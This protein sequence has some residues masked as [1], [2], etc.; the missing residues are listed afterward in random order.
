MAW[1]V[2]PATVDRFDDFATVVNRTRRVNHCWCLSPRLTLRDIEA[3]GEGS[4]ELAMRRLCERPIPPGVIAY[5]EGEP[6]GWCNAGPRSDMSRLTHSRVIPT[7]D[8]VPVWSVVCLVV[9]TGYR[10]QG[11]T[12]QLLDGVVEHARRHGAPVLEAYPVEPVGRMDVTMAFVGTVPMFERAGFHKV[13]QTQGHS[14]GLVR[15]L[16]RRDLT[17]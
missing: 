2:L 13:T 8:D 12:G 5:R 7:L 11:V 9:R 4:R 14:G 3:L 1:E 15:W 17:P 10:R 6:V 16:M